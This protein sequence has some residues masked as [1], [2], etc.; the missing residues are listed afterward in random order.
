MTVE[1]Q[2]RRVLDVQ[3]PDGLVAATPVAPGSFGP[4]TYHELRVH[5]V[6]G[7]TPESMLGLQAQLGGADDRNGGIDVRRPFS[8]RGTTPQPGD[9]S[10]W[11]TPEVDATLRAWSWSSLT[12]G[13]WYQA[14]YL[15]LLPFMIANLAGWMLVAGRTAT[16]DDPDGGPD[17]GAAARF[18]DPMLRA[19]TLLVRLL[20][21]LVTVVF[22]VSV[23]LV[24]ADLVVWQWLHHRLGW[25][26]WTVGLGPV[27]TAAV[28]VGLVGLTRI[29]QRPQV[30]HCPWTDRRDPVGLGF[31][32]RRQELLWN[33]PGI[34]VALRRLHL[35]GG[36]VTIALLAAWPAGPLD[37]TWPSVR[38][39][40]FGLAIASGAMVVLL[41]AWISLGDG[42]TGMRT[43]MVV[44]RY[45][46]CPVA[47]VGVAV[48]ALV[49]IGLPEVVDQDWTT[50]PALRGAALW[51]TLAALV[52]TVALL[53]V[54]LAAGRN[55]KAAN[56][57]SVLLLAV[58]VGA[59]FGA[60]LAG[61]TV[62]YI[63]GSGCAG[64]RCLV[65][66]AHVTWLAIGVTTSLAVFIAVAAVR[67]AILTS[68]YGWRVA[69]PHLTSTG[70][71][72]TALLGATGA[73]LAAIGLDVALGHPGGLP[74]ASTFPPVI[75]WTVIALITAPLVAGALV[76]A[77]TAPEAARRR[78]GTPDTGR[79][80]VYRALG[81][82]AVVGIVVLAAVAVDRSWRIAVL[83][84]PLPPH[85]FADFAIDV[86]VLLPT[87]A[88]LT[89][90]YTGLT[91]QGVRRGIGVLWDVGTFW[92]RWFHPL[93][94]PTYADRA[95]P[96]LATQIDADL[97]APGHRLLLA[98][99]S[100]GAVIA[101]AA[102]L[103]GGRR[104]GL[105][106]L[107][108]GSPWNRLYAEFFPAHVNSESTA[109]IAERLRS[110]DGIRWRNLH[111]ITDPIGGAIPGIAKQ[112]PLSDP[113]H[114]GHSDYARESEYQESAIGLRTMLDP[115]LSP[116]TAGS[117]T[118][119]DTHLP[120][121]L[122]VGEL[123]GSARPI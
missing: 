68:R 63:D 45:A 118:P 108:Y 18:R 74:D 90:I 40:A 122:S 82:L 25:P 115:R 100:Q 110:A 102:L 32:Q 96:Q 2:A 60:G 16:P 31:L 28:L 43:V 95:V 23:Q 33:S 24:L 78:A 119:P 67:A 62:R 86:A 58:S 114:L 98:P 38:A 94:P 8:P 103:G 46:I 13:H 120:H 72:I 113:S 11:R 50:L 89:R 69:V 4:G 99:H 93:A 53:A 84:V 21:L 17:A 123:H 75:A 48:A 85:T 1:P 47:G 66:G 30:P 61:Q 20:G 12:S 116:Q 36:L 111:R 39:T 26:L 27:A 14:F 73:V 35:T 7:T 37:G 107:S 83:G 29:R 59:A 91:N 105:A 44:V 54:G 22:V 92:P 5:G 56:A 77:W 51:V 112:Q 104:P 6:A 19:S 49:P 42:D 121:D 41:L 101:A 15:L 64:P 76:V 87:A 70:T 117:S 109:A 106:M 65:I 79:V 80:G 81:L 88:V 9:I 97:A 34:N 3:S 10:V 55:R 71:W 52:G 57:P